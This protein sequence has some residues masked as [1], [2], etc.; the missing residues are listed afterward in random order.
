MIEHVYFP[1]HGNKRAGTG[2][3]CYG[4]F[5]YGTAD[6]DPVTLKPD[7]PT[8]LFAPSLTRQVEDAA[9]ASH[10]DK[11]IYQTPAGKTVHAPHVR[12][13]EQQPVTNALSAEQQGGVVT[14]KLNMNKV[15]WGWVIGGV[16]AGIALCRR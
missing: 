10:G 6:A 13:S 4:G 3:S 9:A 5:A 8:D 11:W 2:Y 15:P 12:R 16:I 1:I 7:R 14:A